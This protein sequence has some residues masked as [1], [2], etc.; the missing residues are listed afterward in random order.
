MGKS[1]QDTQRTNAER[2]WRAWSG[3]P[4]SAE[5]FGRHG[6]VW[7]LPGLPKEPSPKSKRSFTA[8]EGVELGLSSRPSVRL[9]NGW[10]SLHDSRFFVA[11]QSVAE[12]LRG[13][14]LPYQGR[15]RSTW[16]LLPPLAP[17]GT[18]G[19]RELL[20][21]SE[22]TGWGFSLTVQAVAL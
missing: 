12:P 15:R 13:F 17:A 10:L 9:K 7:E 21:S 6:S 3:L 8:A 5:P 11:S 22:H 16:L 19:A 2:S 1:D 20:D 18:P 4:R 14:H